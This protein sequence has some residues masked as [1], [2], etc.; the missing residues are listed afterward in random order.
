MLFPPGIINSGKEVENWPEI[1]GKPG[2]YID[3]RFSFL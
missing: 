2:L 1:A 3:F